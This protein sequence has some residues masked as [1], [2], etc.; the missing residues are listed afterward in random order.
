MA[1]PLIEQLRFTRTEWR[2]AL[3]GM[4]DADALRHLERM[5]SVGWIV[6]H[7]AWHEQRYFLTRARDETPVPL[8]NDV[9]ASGGAA[10]TPPLSE[11]LAA[12][13]T[14]TRAADPW[15]DSLSTDELLAQLAGPGAKRSVG[16]AIQRVVYHYWFHIGEILAIRQMLG[17]EGLPEFVGNLEA[18]ATYRGGV[19]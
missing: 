4:P 9:A 5:N 6:G 13:R 1:H 16:D 10:T 18:R 7:L 2:R 14:V 11:M 17:H 3:R 19:S 15:L 8:L 12:W